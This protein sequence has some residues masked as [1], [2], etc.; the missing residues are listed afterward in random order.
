MPHLKK[1]VKYKLKFKT[2]PWIAA[3]LHKLISI[4]N[5]LFKKYIRLKNPVKKNEVQQQYKYYRNL[6]STLMKKCKQNYYERFFKNNLSNLKNIWKGIRGLTV[7]KHLPT[8][9]IHMLANKG[10][11]VTDP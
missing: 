5:S 4:K 10:A 2:K 6:L 1:S 3:A 8:S 7:I 11:T 9:N